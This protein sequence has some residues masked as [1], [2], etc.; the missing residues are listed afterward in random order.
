MS[1][2]LFKLFYKSLLKR[3]GFRAIAD[4]N[5][6]PHDPAN[7]K[8]SRADTRHIL[9]EVWRNFDKLAPDIPDEPTLGAKHNVRFACMAL[10]LYRALLAEGL[11]KDYALVLVND[12][13]WL[14]YKKAAF[15]ARAIARIISRDPK[16]QIRICVKVFMV[17]PFSKPG[18][19]FAIVPDEAEENAIAVK[20]TRCV[21]VDYL[22]K[23]NAEDL[24]LA[25]LCNLDY[26]LLE[27]WGGKFDRPC[28]QAVEG[29]DYCHMRF[30]TNANSKSIQVL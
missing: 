29:A 18:Y 30:N 8:F 13:L 12:T 27:Y 15:V 25:C 24:C 4:R 10:S 9:Q 16:R 2:T 17:F 14:L 21:L 7:G 26:P 5:R 3:S 20:W 19:Q 1:D 28:L 11:E 23:Y 22:R 6:N